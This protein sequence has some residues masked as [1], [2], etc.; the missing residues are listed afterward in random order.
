MREGVWAL[1]AAVTTVCVV[2]D[3]QRL[4]VNR[5]VLPRAGWILASL[6]GGPLAG[7]IYCV[8]RRHAKR[9]LVRAV[10]QLVGDASQSLDVRREHLFALRRSGLVGMPVFRTCLET[11]DVER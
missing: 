7:V 1:M 5:I 2:L 10:W 4:K 3:M 6:C 9:S 11:L 8:L